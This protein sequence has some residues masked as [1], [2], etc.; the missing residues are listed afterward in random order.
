MALSLKSR[1][2]RYD[3]RSN[4]KSKSIHLFKLRTFQIDAGYPLATIRYNHEHGNI[5]HSSVV[6]LTLLGLSSLHFALVGVLC[7]V[8]YIYRELQENRPFEYC[9]HAHIC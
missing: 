3:E 6:T 7:G 1:G 2:N 5:C 4:D 9:G 8:K